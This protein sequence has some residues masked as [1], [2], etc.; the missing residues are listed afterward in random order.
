MI[1]CRGGC[2]GLHDAQAAGH[3]EVEEE[4]AS[5]GVDQQVFCAPIHSRDA[6]TGQLSGEPRGD[7]PAQPGLSD[8]YRPYLAT[9]EVRC[10]AA[11]GGFHFRE[12][13]HGTVTGG[14][15]FRVRP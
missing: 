9:L 13:W 8:H 11:A 5:G 1:V 7:P 6:Q 12:F 2:V 10:D 4:S 3:A 14:A 15:T